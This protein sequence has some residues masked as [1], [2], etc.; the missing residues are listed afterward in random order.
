MTLSEKRRQE[1]AWYL[2]NHCERARCPRGCMTPCPFFCEGNLLCG[3][4][5]YLEGLATEMIPD[6]EGRAG[7]AGDGAR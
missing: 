7:S 6:D 2:C 1:A 3:Q 5:W 4:C